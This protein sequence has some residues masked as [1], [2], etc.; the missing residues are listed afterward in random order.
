MGYVSTSDSGDLEVL[1]LQQS[2]AVSDAIGSVFNATSVG[3]KPINSKIDL[4][5][6][7]IK[8]TTMGPKEKANLGERAKS[9]LNDSFNKSTI[10]VLLVRVIEI[11]TVRTRL[12]VANSLFAD[13]SQ[14]SRNL[15]D[16]EWNTKVTLHIFGKHRPPP[17]ISD[18]DSIVMDAINL[19][20]QELSNEYFRV[21]YAQ[22][23]ISIPVSNQLPTLWPSV[24]TLRVLTFHTVL[25][26]H[27][28]SYAEEGG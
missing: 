8:S 6:R 12:L 23:Y 19:K 21:E 13:S 3:D 11:D 28:S 26:E 2:T 15:D 4:I 17:D 20:P 18:F 7:S 25:Y 24:P 10:E 22:Y 14:S 1:L 5:M 9:L 27:I 16:A